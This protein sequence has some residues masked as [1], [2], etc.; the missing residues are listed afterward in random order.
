MKTD[1]TSLRDERGVILAQSGFTVSPRE[2]QDRAQVQ[3]LTVTLFELI[4]PVKFAQ[5]G[6]FV[7]FSFAVLPV[8]RAT[9][10]TLVW[11][12]ENI[13]FQSTPPLQ[14]PPLLTWG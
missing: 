12:S 5:K 6:Q 14:L 4:T 1:S 8:L 7:L 3:Y 2:R 13:I 11:S 10:Y 9:A